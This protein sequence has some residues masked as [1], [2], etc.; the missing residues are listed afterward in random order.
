MLSL[1]YDKQQLPHPSRIMCI[2]C[3]IGWI[4]IVITLYMAC[5]ILFTQGISRYSQHRTVFLQLSEK[6]RVPAGFEGCIK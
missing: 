3:V 6:T 5:T 1:N 2:E 4:D